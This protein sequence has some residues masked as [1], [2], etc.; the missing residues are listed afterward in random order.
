M[1]SSTPPPPLSS[2][3]KFVFEEFLKKLQEENV[4]GKSALEA[5]ALSLHGQKLDPETLR[6]ALFKSDEPSK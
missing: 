4:L 5:L 3:V 2:T 6:E 1:T